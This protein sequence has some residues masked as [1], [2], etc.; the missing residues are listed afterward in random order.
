MRDICLSDLYTTEDIV[1]I[2]QKTLNLEHLQISDRIK[3]AWYAFRSTQPDWLRKEE[4]EC[5]QMLSVVFLA[6]VIIGIR[7]QRYRKKQKKALR[8]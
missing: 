8:G 6:G 5:R 1:Q 7:A 3:D 4:W 2:A